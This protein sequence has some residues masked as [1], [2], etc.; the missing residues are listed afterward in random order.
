MFKTCLN[1]STLRGYD[2]NLSQE[3][4]IAARA[5]YNAIEPWIFEIEAH[6]SAGGSLQDLGQKVRDHG[7]TVQ[8]AIGFFE[9]IVDDETRRRAALEIARR[10]MERVSRIGGELIAAPPMGATEVSNLDLRRVAERYHALCELGHEFGVRPL[11]E[12]WGFSQSLSRLGE[13]AFV[14]VE[15][16]HED[17]CILA[18]V[19]HLHKGG[20]PHSGLSVLRGAHLPLFHV[21]DYPAEPGRE[22]I[23]DEERVY[24][25]DGV[26]PLREIFEI[27]R[28]IGFDGH[29]SLE[30]FNP[31]YWNG[32]AF[33]TART[34]LEKLRRVLPQS[35]TA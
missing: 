9:W 26:A 17:A 34:G 13:A 18:D 28:T 24:P 11:V 21:N 27:L 1:T 33:D 29:V 15:S 12:V 30:L 8:G 32:D 19:Y 2:L 31:T 16:G 5:G 10:D 14:A 4:D 25:G 20:S 23:K 6:Q 22:R 35:A 7:L 3:I